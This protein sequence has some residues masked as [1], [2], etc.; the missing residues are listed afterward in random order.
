MQPQSHRFYN[1]NA[2]C[3]YQGKLKLHATDF[4]TE[5]QYVEGKK[6]A[7]IHNCSNKISLLE[8]T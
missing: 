8:D 4:I 2:D 6:K 1:G 7:I 5:T 3:I